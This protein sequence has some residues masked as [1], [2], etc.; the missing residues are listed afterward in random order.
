MLI[1]IYQTVRSEIN[2]LSVIYQIFG[3]KQIT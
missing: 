1:V 2:N 3:Q